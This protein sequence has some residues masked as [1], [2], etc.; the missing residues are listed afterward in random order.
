MCVALTQVARKMRVHF[1]EWMIDVH[2]RLHRAQTA[3]AQFEKC[4]T[5]WTA[6]SAKVGHCLSAR[7]TPSLLVGSSNV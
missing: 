7:W 2:R 5:S 3:N 6:A 4:D 1:H